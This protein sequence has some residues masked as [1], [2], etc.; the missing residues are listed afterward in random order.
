MTLLLICDMVH[1]Y[2]QYSHAHINE[3]CHNTH[4]CCIVL[5]CVA[6]C[7]SQVYELRHAVCWSVLQCVVLCCSVLQCVAVC[8]S[9]LQ[10]VAV[11]CSVLQCVAVRHMN[12]SFM[13]MT[14]VMQCVAVCCSDAHTWAIPVYCSDA[15]EWAIPVYCSQ[16]WRCLVKSHI[17]MHCSH[18]PFAEQRTMPRRHCNTLQHTATHCNTLQ[19]TAAH[20]N[21]QSSNTALSTKW[22][23]SMSS[24]VMHITYECGML[25]MWMC[26]CVCVTRMDEAYYMSHDVTYMLPVC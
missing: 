2:E 18:V 15:H 10:C 12:G 7:C 6:V 17:Y 1:I 20:C 21:T 23:I 24:K 5:Q 4:W 26:V 19:H 9:V 16:L 14:C 13:R 3:V 8:C 11:C 22:H 25:N